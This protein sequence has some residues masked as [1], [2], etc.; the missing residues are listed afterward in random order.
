ME[1]LE[2]LLRYAI[3]PMLTVIGTLGWSMYKKHDVR[4]DNL[5]KKTNDIE[6]AV[7][8]IKSEFKYVSRDIKE[9]KVI[10]QKM[11]K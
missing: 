5:E 11:D 1:W 2:P 3:L 4:L 6:K 10:L 9:I 7:I 8:E